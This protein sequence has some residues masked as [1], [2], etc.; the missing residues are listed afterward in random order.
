[1]IELDDDDEDVEDTLSLIATTSI[2]Y[3][4]GLAAL[5]ARRIARE[6]RQPG[7]CAHATV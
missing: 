3:E 4:H 2:I 1:M 6:S 5:H 7:S